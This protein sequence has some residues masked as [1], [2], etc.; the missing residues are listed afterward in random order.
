MPWTHVLIPDTL[1]NACLYLYLNPLPYP[2]TPPRT[3]LESHGPTNLESHGPADH[4]ESHGRAD[5]SSHGS[6][7]PSPHGTSRGLHDLLR[8]LECMLRKRNV[9]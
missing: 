1:S 6:A 3:N 2:N 7:D 4:L 8:P 5:L 9:S